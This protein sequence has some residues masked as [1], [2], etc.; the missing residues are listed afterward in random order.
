PT[1][2][3]LELAEW[4]YV[5]N[6]GL[7]GAGLAELASLERLRW[8]RL[9]G[10]ETFA[11]EGL[12]SLPDLRELDLLTVEVTDRALDELAAQPALETLRVAARRRASPAGLRAL[13][14][15]PR[16]GRLELALD[17]SEGTLGVL[18]EL[19]V[20]ALELTVRALTDDS[21]AA[22]AR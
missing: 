13:A 11:G 10:A 1:L 20:Q 2:E 14:R 5:A 3:L 22:L 9:Q 21:C 16:L 17:L 8:L 7:T 4:D 12:P 15:A 18:G 6:D 19:P